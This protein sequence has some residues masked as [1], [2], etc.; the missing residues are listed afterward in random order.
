[1]L[2]NSRQKYHVIE[3]LHHEN[4]DLMFNIYI[5]EVQNYMI[6]FL[7]SLLLAPFRYSFLQLP[8]CLKNTGKLT[9]CTV[10]FE[11]HHLTFELHHLTFELHHLTI[12]HLVKNVW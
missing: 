8:C 11:R 4:K 5:I 1:M 6:F 9:C 10:P 12:Y 7:E 3:Y 2:K